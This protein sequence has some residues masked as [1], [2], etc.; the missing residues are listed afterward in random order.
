MYFNILIA[1][2]AC[3]TYERLSKLYQGQK[4]FVDAADNLEEAGAV[5]KEENPS[6]A[7]GYFK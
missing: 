2:K 4:E 1:S 5:I 6:K 3:E 7:I